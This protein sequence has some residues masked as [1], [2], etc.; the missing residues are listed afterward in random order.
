MLAAQ[1][2]NVDI[3][4]YSNESL[5]EK[6]MRIRSLFAAAA[7]CGVMSIPA[8]AEPKHGFAML[9][10]PK[11]PTDFKNLP[12]ANPDAPQGGILK[13]ATVGTFDSLNPFI[14]KGTGASGIRTYV[15]ESLMGRNWSEPFTLYGLLAESIDVA[16]DR[17]TVTFKIRPEAKFS[18]G[19]PVTAADVV[20]TMETLRDKGRP[21]FKN[22]YSKVTSVATPDERTVVF[23]Q[24]AGDQELPLIMGL[25]PILSKKSWEGKT[26]DET[27]LNP[28]IGS[29]PYTIGEVKPGER[30]TFKKNPNYWAKN[31][32]V[33]KGLWNFDE[34]RYDYYRDGTAAFEAF[35]KGDV[36]IRIENDPVKWLTAYDFPAVAEGKVVT[37]KVEQRS[38]APASGLAFNTRRKIFE[39]IR[40]REALIMAF[41]FEW[42]NANLFSNGYDR[43][44]GY[45]SGSELSSEGVAAGDTELAILGDAAKSMPTAHIDGTFALP[46]S[47]GSGRDRKMLRAVVGKLGEA[48]WTIKDG[49]MVNAAGE[50]F[51]FSI[52]LSSKELEKIVLHYQRT[53]QQIGIEMEVRTVDAAQYASLQKT[54]DYD[55]IPMTLFNSL[56]PG[57]EQKLY[58]GSSGRTTEGTRN[59]PGVSDPAVD[60]GIDAMLKATTREELVSAARAVDRALIA[61]HYM[62]PFYDAGGQWVAR[63]TRIGRPDEQPLPGFEATTLWYAGP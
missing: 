59:Y 33:V 29:G 12:Y 2:L 32:P 30:V 52:V 45:F 39:D 4:H 8:W 34:V 13:Q 54:Y 5:G 57:N 51:K 44:Y 41:D 28:I 48:G 43:T 36:D 11:L 37:Q 49:K 46:K 53:L 24:D 19:T 60:R 16:P 47:D 20:F 3:A 58:Y 35:K 21:N 56:S 9:G 63:W 27:T 42:A 6:K 26:F 1:H 50:P 17:Q 18:D 10:E 7:L 31:V 62:L 22:S 15:F 61:G 23:K 38:P 40:V 55:M 25:M 14:V